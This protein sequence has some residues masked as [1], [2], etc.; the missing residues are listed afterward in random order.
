MNADYVTPSI[1]LLEWPGLVG[2]DG[3]EAVE[4]IKNETGQF[5]VIGIH[6][7][8]NRVVFF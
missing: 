3:D 1:K 5:L 4:I 6:Q 8:V 7:R 2:M